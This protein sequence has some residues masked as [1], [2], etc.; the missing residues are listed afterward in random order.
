MSKACSKT[1][2]KESLKNMMESA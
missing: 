1:L 2:P